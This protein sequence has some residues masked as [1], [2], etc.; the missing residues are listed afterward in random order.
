MGIQIETY[1]RNRETLEQIINR[2]Q[3][4]AGKTDTVIE[5]IEVSA[6]AEF[7]N[8]PT[9]DGSTERSPTG[10]SELAIN[11]KLRKLG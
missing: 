2:L 3:N 10:E 8:I 1:V 11:I 4:I 9:R 6:I 5:Q 7:E